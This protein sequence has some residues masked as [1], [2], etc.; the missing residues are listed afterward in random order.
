MHDSGYSKKMTR[1]N[2][3]TATQSII[4]IKIWGMIFGVS[5]L[6]GLLV[7]RVVD[8]QFFQGKKYLALADDNRFFTLDVPAERGVIL[9]RYQESLVW[10]QRQYFLLDK[11]DQL[12]SGKRPVD[13]ETALEMMA[14]ASGQVVYEHQRLYRYGSALAHV[15]GYVGDV[16][17]E[18]KKARPELDISRQYGKTGLEKVFDSQLQGEFGQEVYEINALG[19]RQRL[20]KHV[21]P[22]PGKNVSTTLDP[23]LSQVALKA[24]EG[25]QG[26][27]VILDAGTGEVLSLVNSPAFDPNQPSKAITDP[28]QPFFNRAVAGN[29][30]PGS[31]F[32]LVSALAGLESGKVTKDTTVDD[33]GTLKVGEY[34]YG[35][36]Y[37]RQ[38]G[39]TEGVISMVRAIARSN[40]IYF[41]KL[42]EWTGPEKIGEMASLLGLGKIPGIELVPQAAGLVPTPDWKLSRTGE[43]W[44]LGNT[45][46]MSIGQ[47]DVLVSPLQIAQLGQA[48]ANQGTVCRPTLLT[49]QKDTCHEAGLTNTNIDLVLEGMIEACSPGGT[50]FPLFARNERLKGVAGEQNVTNWLKNGVTACKTGTAEFGGANEQGYRATHGWLVAIVEPQ[51]PPLESVAATAET[52]SYLSWRQKL[53]K[54]PLPERVVM[55]ALVESDEQNKYREGSRDAG[56]VIKDILSWIETGR[57]EAIP[58]PVI[59]Q[60]IGE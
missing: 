52:A 55:V 57:V 24:L 32:K 37:F 31:V 19:Q 3:K 58:A 14:T 25:K 30:P 54:K 4:L 40:D 34:E 50:S 35:N 17:A 38:Y 45:Y 47:G 41:Y 9:D 53:L 1:T 12:F 10:N 27:V 20:V 46:H 2:K 18:E 11:P 15:I 48:V 59:E 43:R 13:R 5:L 26:A 42:G 33:Q 36:W 8:I 21:Q 23:D 51:L 16:T 60:A 22:T 6:L 49:E 7:I 56:P 28:K 29:Y 44:F 39:G